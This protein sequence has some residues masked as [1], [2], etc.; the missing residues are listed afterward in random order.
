MSND[1][2]YIGLFENAE[3]VFEQFHVSLADREGVEIVLAAYRDEDYCGN[4]FVLFRKDGQVFEVNGS[5]CSCNGLEG[6]WEPEEADT[7]NLKVRLDAARQYGTDYTFGGGADA[8]RELFG[9]EKA[10]A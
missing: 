6:Q 8:L 4:A 1:A 7:A 2:Q 10:S 5:H 3:D 9:W